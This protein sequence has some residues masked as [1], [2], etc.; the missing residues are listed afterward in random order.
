MDGIRFSL[1]FMNSSI[2]FSP[3]F[4][5]LPKEIAERR[6]KI[7][8]AAPAHQ[9]GDPKAKLHPHGRFLECGAR[10]LYLLR[11]SFISFFHA[12]RAPGEFGKAKT[13]KTGPPHPPPSLLPPG[14]CGRDFR[15][16]HF[17]TRSVNVSF[18]EC[19]ASNPFLGHCV[20]M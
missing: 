8:S 12:T 4:W 6:E 17:R 20:C 1:R 7:P 14:F 15:Q 18:Y 2:T 19:A 13:S 9:V 3:L 5:Q 11:P 16:P 10:D